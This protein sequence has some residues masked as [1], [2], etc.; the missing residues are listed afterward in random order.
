M[1]RIEG[2]DL[3]I[4]G[5]E[6]GISDNP[7][8]GIN[9]MRG[10]NIISV[11]GEA[12]VS[13]SPTAFEFPHCN[14]NVISAD[15][16]TDIVTIGGST[17]SLDPSYGGQAVVFTGASLPTGLTPG[18]IY[19]ISP[20]GT[21]SFKVYS[22]PSRSNLVNITAT[23]TGTF[24]TI[25]IK[26]ITYFDRFTGAGV[27]STGR[28]WVSTGNRYI[29]L[30]NT[31]SGTTGLTNAHGNG[32]VYYR[33]YLFV[34]Q[35][36]RI[37][38]TAFNPSDQTAGIS[39]VL[40]WDP[41]TGLPAVGNVNVFNTTVSQNNPHEALVGQDDVIYI[42][43]AAFVASLRQ[44][45]GQTFDP[46]STS[47]YVWAKQALRLP[48]YERAN[49]LEELGQNLLIGGNYNYIYPW[50]RISTSFTYPIKIVDNQIV[51]LLTVNTNTY[52][53]AG[54]RGR[55]YYTNGVQ[56]QFYSKIPDHISGGLDPV[57][58]WQ[59]CAYFKNQ[60]YFGVSAT[61]NLGTSFV[62]YSGLWAIDITTNALRVPM[63]MSTS[64]SV[65]SAVYADATNNQGYSLTVSWKKYTTPPTTG[66]TFGIDVSSSTPYT[67]YVGYTETD[68]IPVGTYLK[69]KTFDG[70]EFK[71]S[72]PLKNGEGIRISYRSSKDATYGTPIEILGTSTYNPLSDF[73]PV[74]FDQS[75][76][77]QFKIEQKSIANSPSFTRLYELRLKQNG[78]A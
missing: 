28:V 60:I 33:G 46:S 69:K 78:A 9:D 19:W 66:G 22:D 26:D 52:I 5:W 35:N 25:D 67:D 48:Y 38:Y 70:I 64:T 72:H 8:N 63:L 41:T 62:D 21:L 7:Y 27:D 39:W 76:W 34:F 44:A 51:H 50:D 75:Q 55:I 18:T 6:N 23:G 65:A 17:G 57:F 29:Y 4:S 43:D 15:P 53:F 31:V 68:L 77:A 59:N 24:T 2:N 10:V 11:P 40:E 3:V 32:I 12:S 13:F 74:S 61:T 30:G 36:S 1:Y 16:D 45:T 54:K 56:A 20:Q 42:T 47:T 73:I 14:G 37:C 58:T 71:L 49:C